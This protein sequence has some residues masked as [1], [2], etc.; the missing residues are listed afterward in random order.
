MEIKSAAVVGV[1]GKGRA[2]PAPRCRPPQGGW[3][4][5]PGWAPEPGSPQG[6]AG[7]V[8]APPAPLRV[9]IAPRSEASKSQKSRTRLICTCEKKHFYHKRC[10]E[11]NFQ[12]KILQVVLRVQLSTAFAGG[13]KPAKLGNRYSGDY[14][15]HCNTN[16]L[17]TR[18]ELVCVELLAQVGHDPACVRDMANPACTPATPNN[19]PRWKIIQLQQGA[20]QSFGVD[21]FPT[22]GQLASCQ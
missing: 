4:R 15:P 3:F 16:P 12:G 22:P 13:R 9:F 19:S 2:E 7:R 6:A 14:L 10:S 18:F 8:R 5:P 11:V 20:A 17:L 1:P 21:G